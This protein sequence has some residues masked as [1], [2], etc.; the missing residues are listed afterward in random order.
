[1]VVDEIEKSR[2]SRI[3]GG[4]SVELCGCLS[5]LGDKI[6]QRQV[7]S[8]IEQ[9]EEVVEWSSKVSIHQVNGID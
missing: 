5:V 8:M 2:S 4:R 7:Q 6:V 3:Q 1:M 9:E